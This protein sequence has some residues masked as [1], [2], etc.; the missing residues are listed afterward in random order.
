M[1]ALIDLDEI[2]MVLGL[3]N[4]TKEI[5]VILR[6]H[7]SNSFLSAISNIICN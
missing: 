2:Q 3:Q 6:E 7:S 5:E 4:K 1:S